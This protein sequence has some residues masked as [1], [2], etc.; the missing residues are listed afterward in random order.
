MIFPGRRLRRLLP[1]L[2]AALLVPS[3][4]AAP[5]QAAVRDKIRPEFFGLGIW[6]GPE[7]Q[8]SWPA[9]GVGTVRL[10]QYWSSIERSSGVYDWSE[11]DAQVAT[12]E[13]HGVEPLIIIEGTP[14]FHAV[15]KG[16]PTS[17]SP[18]RLNAYRNYV[19]ALVGRYGGRASYQ[20]WSE[21]SVTLFYTG[22]PARMGKMTKILWQA[23]RDLAPTAYVVAASFPLRGANTPTRHW[24]RT[25]WSQKIGRKTTADFVD[26]AAISAYPMPDEDP[27][28]ALALTRWAR[29]SLDRHGFDGQLWAT[30]INYGASGLAT[31]LAPISMKRQAAYVVRT[32]ALQAVSGADRVYWWRWERHETV[33]TSLNN[34]KGRLTR[35]G[36]AFREVEDWLTGMRPVGCNVKGG[37]TTCT[38]RQGRLKRHIYWTRSGKTRTVPAPK[39]AKK[40]FTSL[41]KKSST[42]PG[43]VVTVDLSPIMVESRRPRAKP[44]D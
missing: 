20:V 25:Y 21:A 16:A 15:G 14:E 34:G 23:K 9:L 18:P 29:R 43:K 38:F 24:W 4:L 13:E 41:G 27:E 35:A 17:A 6:L 42:K 11:L 10:V 37:V 5:S 1:F 30:E 12:A 32:Y 8:T 44:R 36:K 3:L 33:N 39:W 2:L 19:Q 22:S 31:T 28:D 40:E 7:G 26:A